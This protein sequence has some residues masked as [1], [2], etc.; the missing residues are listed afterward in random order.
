MWVAAACLAV[1][2]TAVNASCAQPVALPTAIASAPAVFVGTV[3]GLDRGGRVATVDVD[4]VW[5]GDGVA[6]VVQVAG[7][8]DLASAATSVDRTY[9]VG[10]RY[11]FV[12]A[13]GAG[14]HFEDNSCTLTQPYSAALTAVRPTTA[15]RPLVDTGGTTPRS[16]LVGTFAAAAALALVAAILVGR[17]RQ[18]GPT[19]D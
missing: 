8:P 16:L 3:T 17:R 18:G 15:H 12:P 2:P 4:E 5:K 7:S 6:A 9:G 1:G 19:P 14:D 10:Q 11:L 13:G